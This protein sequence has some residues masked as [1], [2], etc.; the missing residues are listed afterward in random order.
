MSQRKKIG[1]ALG[2]GGVRGL[3]HIG[4]I[5][6]LEE[7]NIQIDYIAGTSIGAWVGAHYAL[8][9]DLNTL[10]EFTY[11]KRKEKIFSFLDASFSGGLIKGK[12]IEKMLN[13]WLESSDF[14]DLKIPLNIIATDLVKAEPV[15]F[16]SGS[17]AY[18][19]RASMAIPGIFKPLSYEDR[20][21]VDGG[22]TT[23][24]PDKV[25]RKMGADIV[26]SVNLNNFQSPVKF[27][28]KSPSVTE[29]ALRS[30]EVFQ[31]YLS[32]H[33]LRETD[34]NISPPLL[35]RPSFKNYLIKG[36]GEDLIKVGE[37]AM[38]KALPELL[39]MLESSSNN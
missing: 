2:S 21:L 6:V 38:T 9:K 35:K 16:D 25:V 17:L 3:A 1:L 11:G 10:K 7:N 23:P 24:V 27:K 28:K 37:D 36:E 34:I 20:F 33:S 26:I 31:C 30:Y 39:K 8:Y 5:K 12:K 14:N 22:L 32:K 19:A 13:T 15:I 4:V 18:A 29:V